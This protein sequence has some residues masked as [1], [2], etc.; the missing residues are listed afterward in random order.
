MRGW[1][2]RPIR[3]DPTDHSPH[4][5]VDLQKG[6]VVSCNAYFAQLGT[7]EVGPEA[8]LETAKRYGISVAKPNT[9]EQ[10]KDALPQASYGQGQVVAT[11]FQMARVAATVANGG[12]MPEGR[13]VTDESNTR[14][15]RAPARVVE[16]ALAAVLAAPCAAW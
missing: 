11:P 1:G 8:L 12:A 16:P 5:T 2:R 3:D 14:R 10:L 9:P 15:G 6:I 4:G 13:W 7:Y